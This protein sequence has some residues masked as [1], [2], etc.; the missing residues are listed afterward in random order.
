M[1]IE[2]KDLF[3]ATLGIIISLGLITYC[4]TSIYMDKQMFKNSQVMYVDTDMN[5]DQAVNAGGLFAGLSS[6]MEVTPI[7]L[8]DGELDGN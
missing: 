2:C 3:L 5:M 1:G 8:K 4:A 7:I 6:S